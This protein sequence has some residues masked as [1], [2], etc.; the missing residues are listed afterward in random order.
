[1]YNHKVWL[2]LFILL[3]TPALGQFCIHD[4]DTDCDGAISISEVIAYMDLWTN[5]DVTL[6]DVIEV[7]R[8][9]KDSQSPEDCIIGD[10]TIAHGESRVFYSQESVS[11]GTTCASVRETRTCNNGVLSGS[12]QYSTCEVTGVLDCTT[13]AFVAHGESKMFFREI[14][15]PF[16]STCEGQTRTCD[17]GVLSGSNNYVQPSCE[18]EIAKVLEWNIMIDGSVI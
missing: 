15:V 12:Y 9:W 8:L 1:M 2:L 10:I 17:N 4:A 16:G 5:G 6:D 14:N 18:N 7:I 11:Y 3:I 13:P